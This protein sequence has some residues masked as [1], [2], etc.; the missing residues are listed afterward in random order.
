[1][2]NYRDPGNECKR[3][4]YTYDTFYPSQIINIR[5]DGDAKR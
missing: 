4:P 3:G 1:M 5:S 2:E